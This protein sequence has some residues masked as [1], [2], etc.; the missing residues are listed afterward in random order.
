MHDR[1]ERKR[2]HDLRPDLSE[3][4]VHVV[5]RALESDP[6]ERYASVGAMQRGLTH[7]LGLESGLMPPVT[8]AAIAADTDAALR[9]IEHARVE[10]IGRP[11]GGAGVALEGVAA[12]ADCRR[13]RRG[14]CRVDG[15]ASCGARL[16]RRPRL[17]RSGRSS[18]SRSRWSRQAIARWP[19]GIG[20]VVMERV[21]LL[22]GVR[23]VSFTP[24]TS[25]AAS[26]AEAVLTR[27]QVGGLVRGTATWND[28]L[29]RV[30]VAVLHAGV[31]APVFEQAFERPVE[32]AAELPR[33]VA[34]EMV[35]WLGV[36]A[37]SDESSRLSRADD[38]APAASRPTCAVDW[39]CATCPR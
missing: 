7:A 12:A 32:R 31:G 9:G 26:T 23:V 24:E 3:G 15:S 38:A 20:E 27:H 16:R 28:G 17:G 13:P 18:S 2:L 34:S 6:A 39:R 19:K 21:R 37:S 14:D 36:H 22:P 35:R 1:G 33:L 11:T 25:Q 30:R 5:E 10:R 4:F 29:A 8:L